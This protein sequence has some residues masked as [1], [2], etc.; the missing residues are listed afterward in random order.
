MICQSLQNPPARRLWSVTA[1]AAVLLCTLYI[2][3]VAAVQ[4][5][6]TACSAQWSTAAL[7]EARSYLAATSLPSQGLAI[8]A[9]GDKGGL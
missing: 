2:V 8:F 1:A 3:G 5:E 6:I 7:S 9:G 4:Q